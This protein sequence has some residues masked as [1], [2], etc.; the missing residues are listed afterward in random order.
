MEEIKDH[1]QTGTVK[2]PSAGKSDNAERKTWNQ[3]AVNVVRCTGY[4]HN[5]R[6]EWPSRRHYKEGRKVP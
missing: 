6:R 5:V 4:Y 2:G 3:A 1:D